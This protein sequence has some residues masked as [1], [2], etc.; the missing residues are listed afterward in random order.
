M[1]MYTLL[2][3]KRS[4][5][6][7]LYCVCYFS[8]LPC[9]LFAAFVR[10]NAPIWHATQHAHSRVTPL[11]AMRGALLLMLLLIL[12][13]VASRSMCLVA[14][15]W[16]PGPSTFCVEKTSLARMMDGYEQAVQ[17]CKYV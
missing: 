10:W 8:L 9:L 12:L 13:P 16:H 6:F 14:V 1:R 11:D 2:P 5:F 7:L 4:K 17:S 3:K 15:L